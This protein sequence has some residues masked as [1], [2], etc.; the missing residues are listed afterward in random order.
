MDATAIDVCS[1]KRASSNRIFEGVTKR[2][3]RQWVVFLAS[4][5]IW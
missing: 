1:L 2:E 5:C 3:N 4:S